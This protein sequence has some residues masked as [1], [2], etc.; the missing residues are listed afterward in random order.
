LTSPAAS[1]AL[2]DMAMMFLWKSRSIPAIPMAGRR[3]AMVV[4][5]RQTKSAT[6]TARCTGL[7][8]P[9]TAALYAE[10]GQIV[11][12]TS[13]N[14]PVSANSRISSALSLG[15][16]LRFAPSIIWIMQSR[17]VFPGSA[18]IRMTI[19]LAIT[20][21]PPVTALRSPPDSLTTGAD[22]PVM[23]ASLIRAAPAITSPSLG[24][25]SPVWTRTKSPQRRSVDATVSKACENSGEFNFFAVIVVLDLRSDA[26]RAFPRPSASDSAKLEK[27]TVSQSQTETIP[28]K[29]ADSPAITRIS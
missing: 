3:A 16:F 7:P 5:A 19:S 11:T 4:G 24:T 14:I 15:V 1:I 20:V 9:D 13:R 21:V 28:V 18:V 23:A 10:T 2:P 29:R 6:R 26:A 12:T 25:M 27:S 17:K 22:S 8:L